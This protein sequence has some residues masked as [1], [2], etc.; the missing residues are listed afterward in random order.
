MNNVSSSYKAFS[1]LRDD[2]FKNEK[3]ELLLIC[4]E[5][6]SFLDLE[7]INVKE[8][9]SKADAFFPCPCKPVSRLVGDTGREPASSL[10]VGEAKLSAPM[11]FL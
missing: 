10:Q 11:L 9:L 8:K 5:L 1:E 2:L 7:I 6:F 4:Q 3:Q